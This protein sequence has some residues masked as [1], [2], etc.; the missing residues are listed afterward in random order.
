MERVLLQPAKKSKDLNKVSLLLQDLGFYIINTK[1]L[2]VIKDLIHKNV[3]FEF[4]INLMVKK[5]E[6]SIIN[7]PYQLFFM[8]KSYGFRSKRS[9]CLCPCLCAFVIDCETSKYKKRQQNKVKY[10]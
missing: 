10:C 3:F 7:T 2:I 8:N 9:Q 1:S 5:M 6:N 4:L